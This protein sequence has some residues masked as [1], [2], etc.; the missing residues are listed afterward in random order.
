M[1]R[2]PAKPE[3]KKMGRKGIPDKE[4]SKTTKHFDFQPLE[5]KLNSRAD[6]EIKMKEAVDRKIAK[7]T[8]VTKQLI[9]DVELLEDHNAVRQHEITKLTNR[10]DAIEMRATKKGMLDWFKGKV[11]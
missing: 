5:D 11:K 9:E 2:W 10:L 7:L 6:N 3:N 8:A 4:P 1:P